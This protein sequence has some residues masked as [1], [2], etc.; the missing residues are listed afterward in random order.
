MYEYAPCNP[1]ASM[2][3][4]ITKRYFKRR[5]VNDDGIFAVFRDDDDDERIS[6]VSFIRSNDDD[7]PNPNSDVDVDTDKIDSEHSVSSNEHDSD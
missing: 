1:S 4:K 7:F 5:I 2:M 6:S 3:T